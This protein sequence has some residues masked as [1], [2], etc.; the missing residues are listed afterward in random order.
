MEKTSI[1]AINP[2][3]KIQLMIDHLSTPDLLTCDPPAMISTCLSRFLFDIQ[4]KNRYT[5][6]T[7]QTKL[8]DPAR[9]CCQDT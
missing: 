3:P 1:T 6:N 4:A 9:E 7:L 8:D 2:N 5:M